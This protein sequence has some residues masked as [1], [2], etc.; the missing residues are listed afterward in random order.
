MTAP[1]S[2]TKAEQLFNQLVDADR[3]DVK[4]MTA[5]LFRALPEAKRRPQ[6]FILRNVTAA[7]HLYTGQ[8]DKAVDD[9]N[10]AFMLRDRQPPAA[11]NE[12]GILLTDAGLW[13]R[14]SVVFT[15]LLD[16]AGPTL[17]AAAI[18][19]FDRAVITGDM[20]LLARIADDPRMKNIVDENC[21]AGRT[22]LNILAEHG[23]I[24]L[25]PRH[26]AT[27]RAVI[28]DRIVRVGMV[29]NDWDGMA[30]LEYKVVGD[31]ASR[32]RLREEINDR[33]AE[34]YAGAGLNPGAYVGVFQHS[35]VPAPRGGAM[36]A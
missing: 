15:E 18:N 17:P 19:A 13:D 10:A 8:R 16:L 25:L 6:D 11:L 4:A 29:V 35:L 1:A 31:Q 32:A 20:T 9:L 34:L 7:A 22:A 24:D 14:C 2:Q 33:L 12:L 23:L 28:G 27:V 30:V 3:D 5:I 21:H 36:V 26:Q